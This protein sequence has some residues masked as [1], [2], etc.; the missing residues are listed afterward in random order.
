MFAQLQPTPP[1][2]TKL[3]PDGNTSTTLKAG[4]SEGPLF[5]IVIV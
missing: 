3:T 2:D 1:A 5:E 4:A